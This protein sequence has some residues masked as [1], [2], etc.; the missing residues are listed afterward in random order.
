MNVDK[1]KKYDVFINTTGGI[2]DQYKGVIVFADD[3][4]VTVTLADGRIIGYP[5]C[6]IDRINL[7]PNKDGIMT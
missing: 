3:I 2:K 7:T 6:N 5:I 1:K 4:F